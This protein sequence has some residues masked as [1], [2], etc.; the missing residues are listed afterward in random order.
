VTYGGT[1]AHLVAADLPQLVRAAAEAAAAQGFEESCQPAHG[2]LLALLAGGVGSGM[3]GETGTG[4]GV[5]LAWLATGAPPGARLVS[6]ER[7]PAR[8]IAARSVFAD[9]PAVRVLTGDWTELG[10][11]GPFDLLVLDGGGQGKGDEPPVDVGR[12]VRPGGLVVLDDFTPTTSWAPRYEGRVDTA[13][14]HWLTHPALLATELPLTP[15]AAT[16]VARHLPR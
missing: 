12:W 11:Y 5:G 7:E 3:I 1:R 9:R 8:A 6:V 14:L 2:R 15:T 4:G 10:A 13:R 16:I